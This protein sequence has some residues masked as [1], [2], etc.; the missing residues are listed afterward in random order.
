MSGPQQADQLPHR[1]L[2]QDPAGLA[3][4]RLRVRRRE[5]DVRHSGEAGSAQKKP[6]HSHCS[7]QPNS[8][9]SHAVRIGRQVRPLLPAKMITLEKLQ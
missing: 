4:R 9:R 2:G 7:Q 3:E 8:A 1:R 5:T 6:R